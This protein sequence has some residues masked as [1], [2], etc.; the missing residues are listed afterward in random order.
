MLAAVGGAVEIPRADCR[1]ASGRWKRLVEQG[2][3]SMDYVRLG[4]SSLRVSRI[5]LGA[6][7]IGDRGWRSWVLP[8]DEARPIVAHAL[9]LGVNLF[10]TCDYYSAGESERVLGRLLK[11][12]P[13]DQVVIATK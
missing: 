10:D 11:T 4:K 12:V 6:M 8:E 1:I 7:G 5:A 13:R 3:S 9:D 2:E